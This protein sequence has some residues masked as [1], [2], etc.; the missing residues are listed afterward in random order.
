ML[1]IRSFEATDAIGIARLC[2]LEGWPSWTP[3]NVAAAFAAPGVIAVTALEGG[4]IVGAA[5]LLTDTCVMAYLGLLIV[6]P[7]SRRRGVGRALIAEV[8]ARC[9]LTRVDLLSEV[10]STSFYESLPHRTKP[11][12]R[13]YAKE[14]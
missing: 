4:E 12:Y 9:G 7:E 1:D 11:G 3:Q 14:K 13:L 5:Q 10:D 2:A 8:F 6:A